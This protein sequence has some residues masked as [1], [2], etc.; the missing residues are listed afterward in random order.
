MQ[1]GLQKLNLKQEI[2]EMS[3]KTKKQELSEV[4]I[5]RLKGKMQELK[6]K[7]EKFLAEGVRD[8]GLNIVPMVKYFPFGIIP[9]LEIVKA[10]EEDKKKSEELLKQTV[11]VPPANSVIRFLGKKK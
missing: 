9:T 3:K 4:E 11:F 10:S 2:N 5:E 6:K 7:F 1:I 8:Y